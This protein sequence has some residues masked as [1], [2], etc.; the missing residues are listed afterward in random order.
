MRQQLHVMCGSHVIPQTE[1]EVGTTVII[2]HITEIRLQVCPLEAWHLLRPGAMIWNIASGKGELEE[3]ET[4]APS[5]S[6]ECRKEAALR[7]TLSVLEIL[8]LPS[9]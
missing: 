9:G 7:P 4:Q 1:A 5:L 2:T 3:T 8:G 6:W